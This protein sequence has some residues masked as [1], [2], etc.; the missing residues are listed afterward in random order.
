M[1]ILKD[2][3]VMPTVESVG[4]YFPKLVRE[5]ICNMTDDIDKPESVH[6]QKVVHYIWY[7]QAI[8]TP[9]TMTD[10]QHNT[11][12]QALQEQLPPRTITNPRPSHHS[13]YQ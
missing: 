8:P 5:F 12:F 2:A 10:H 9:S 4:P 6:F 13:S 11:R 3:R 7:H 1:G